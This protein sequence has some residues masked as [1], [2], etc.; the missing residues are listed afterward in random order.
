VNERVEDDSEFRAA[1]TADAGS[2]SVTLLKF[3]LVGSTEISGAVSPSDE[4]CL[5]RADT[6]AVESLV[7]SGQ[8]KIEWEGDGGLLVFGYPKRAWTRPRPRYVPD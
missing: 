6:A 3:D 5:R 8:V 2:R 1:G 7:K 4:L